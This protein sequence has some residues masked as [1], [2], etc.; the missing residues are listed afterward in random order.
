VHLYRR[1]FRCLN[2]RLAT[3]YTATINGAQRSTGTATV[4]LEGLQAEGAGP[5]TFSEEFA[6]TGVVQLTSKQQCKDGGW[7]S[8]GF[9]SQ[10]DCVSFLATGG[11]NPPG[12]L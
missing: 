4:S 10:G 9:E 11:K 8:F 6:S 3:I 7:Q 5:P 12:G 1:R 2:L